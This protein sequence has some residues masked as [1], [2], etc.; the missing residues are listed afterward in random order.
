PLPGPPSASLPWG[1]GRSVRPASAAARP[2]RIPGSAPGP[3]PSFPRP[4]RGA[5]TAPPGGRSVRRPWPVSRREA[6]EGLEDGGG[7]IVPAVLHHL[8]DYLA[9]RLGVELDGAL[10]AVHVAGEVHE[11]QVLS[12]LLEARSSRHEYVGTL[13]V[14][15]GGSSPARAGVAA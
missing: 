14:K 10:L 6:P 9:L 11:G 5:L 2:G 7:G 15:I 1:A 8:V 3:G 13:V 4:G 12:G